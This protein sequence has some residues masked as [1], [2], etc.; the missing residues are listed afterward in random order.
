M[1]IDHS[2]HPMQVADRDEQGETGA[3]PAP[4]EPRRPMLGRRGLLSKAVAAAP[5]AV[6][7]AV[8]NPLGSLLPTATAA[9]APSDFDLLAFAQ[10]IEL[11]VVDIY[12]AAAATKQVTGE[13]AALLTT[14]AG[15]HTAHAALFAEMLG[16]ANVTPPGAAN[17]A[18]SKAYTTRVSSAASSNAVLEILQE[19]EN[20]LVATYLDL[21]GTINNGAAAATIGTIAPVDAQHATVLGT[22]LGTALAELVPPLQTDAGKLDPASY[23][24]PTAAAEGA[25]DS[26]S[27]DHADSGTDTAAAT[28]SDSAASTDSGATAASTTTATS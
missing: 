12:T 24:V 8:M 1:Q 13:A 6:L 2:Q 3:A 4:A 15:H 10:T 11:S 25:T 16:E 22:A 20:A 26:G 18:L 19:L 27:H 23:P 9:E 14:F 28:G 5:A 7:G 21:L 17:P